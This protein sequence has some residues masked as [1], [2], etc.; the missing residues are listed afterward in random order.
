MGF[1]TRLNAFVEEKLRLRSYPLKVAVLFTLIILL[2]IFLSFVVDTFHSFREIREELTLTANRSAKLRTVALSNTIVT[3]FRGDTALVELIE[4]SGPA[5]IEPFL[6]DYIVCAKGEDFFLGEDYREPVRTALERFRGRDLYFYLIPDRWLGITVVRKNGKTYAF[7]HSVPYMREIL[8]G[9][10]GVIAKYGAEFY[11]GSRPSVKEG[12]ILVAYENN[13]SNAYMYVVIP[14]TSILKTLLGERLALYSRLYL[15]FV[16]FLLFSYLLWAKLINYPIRRLRNIAG[17]LEKGNYSVDFSDLVNAKDEFGTIARLLK[18]F[19]EDTRDRLRKQELILE[20][21]LGII[22]SPE[23]IP[24][25]VKDTLHRLNDI[26]GARSS[27]F[28]A[29]D[30]HS[31]RFVLLVPSGASEEDVEALREIYESRRSELF[32]SPEELVCFRETREN[33]W[34]EAVLFRLDEDTRGA[35]LLTFGGNMERTDE[36]YLKVICQHL[37][38]TIRLSHLATTDPLTGVP[39]RRALEHDLKNYGRL[40]KRYGKRLSLIMID[41][42]NFKGVN[43]T[44]GHSA[45]DEILKRV[46]RLVKENIRETDVL[47][48]YGGEEFAILCPETG[49]EG[50]YELAERIRENVRGTRFWIDRDKFIYIT[51][52]LGVASYPEDTEDPQELLMIADISLYRAKNEGKDR[53]IMLRLPEDKEAYRER[54]KVEKDLRELILRGATTYHLQPI[55]DLREGKVYGYELLFRVVKDGEVIP[56]GRFLGKIEDFSIMEDIDLLTVEYLKEIVKDKDLDSF[57]FFINLSPR[58]LERGMIFGELSQLPRHARSRTFIEITE[59][60]TF[61]NIETAISYLDILKTIGFRIAMDDFGSGFSSISYMRH[62]VK[63]IDLL[64]IDGSLVRNVSR[65]PYNRAILESIKIMADRFSVDVVA[66]FIESE[67]D[68]EAVKR[69]GI[70]FG[71][72]YYLSDDYSRKSSPR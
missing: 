31:G 50:T 33:L 45:G 61:L 64:K 52:S 2:S 67:S 43:D 71:Q 20:T 32:S 39:N 15:V 16:L 1:S 62:F 11:F 5:G 72:G 41:I 34:V 10:L 47:Y 38:S 49:K 69:I 37:V 4:Q 57:C 68:L 54:F 27:L 66:E 55:F 53:T 23:E 65:D 42:D 56:I 30:I 14:F 59:R 17:E 46:A 9:K 22:G 26:L 63:F 28:L 18:K 8:S 19:T 7:C 58:S 48:R 12:D 40:A 21:A 44:Y 3:F 24:L 29:E 51:V 6:G 36:S 25:F 35:I 60:E 13:Y 70:R